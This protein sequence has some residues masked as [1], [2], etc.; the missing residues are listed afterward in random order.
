MAL[1]PRLYIICGKALAK[2]I[3]DTLGTRKRITFQKLAL[4]GECIP[5]FRFADDLL[6]F[7]SI[8]KNK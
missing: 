2:A 7:V 4:Q 5:I 1:S 8:S 6:L 3:H